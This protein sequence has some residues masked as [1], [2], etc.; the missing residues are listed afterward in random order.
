MNTPVI[1][2]VST[3]VPANRFTQTDVAD[4]FLA[5]QGADYPRARGIRAIFERAGV[6][7]RYMAVDQSFFG[8]PRTTQARNDYYMQAAPRLGKRTIEQVLGNLSLKPSAIDD[9]IVVSCTG[10]SIPGLDL[11]LARQLGMRAD[12]RRSCVLG[13]GCY[14][15]F[16]GLLRAA[17]SAAVHPDKLTL[18]LSIEL[19]SLHLQAE[20][21]TENIVSTSLFADGA[22]A[23]VVG[24]NGH[25]TD[26]PRIVD[27]ATHCDYQTLDHM[28]FEVTD[29]GFQMRLSSYVPDVLAANVIPFVEKLLARN[30][31]QR[32]DITHWGVHPG[33]RKILDYIQNQL[34]LSDK[35]MIHSYDVL[36]EYGNMSSAT[37]LFILE[38]IQRC[39]QPASGEYGVLL[40]FGPGLTMEGLL[41]QW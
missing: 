30:G 9:F 18:V 26:G 17:E 12:L 40:A 29:S 15:S 28:A 35:Q 20:P 22:A 7:T 27:S 25:V 16:P 19:C 5:L 14:G 11:L 36:Q 6:A 23:V 1:L 3:Q 13:M 33:S 38:R 2:G 4:Y 41:V 8:R 31:L 10:F 32:P 24:G 21:T 37:I 34:V 39:T